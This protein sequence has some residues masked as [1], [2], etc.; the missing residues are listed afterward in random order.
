MPDIMKTKVPTIER[1]DNLPIPHI[2]WPDVHPEPNFVP[3]P[4]N[5]PPNIMKRGLVTGISNPKFLYWKK[6]KITGPTI[7]P[8]IKNDLQTKPVPFAEITLKYIS[9]IPV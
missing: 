5:N 3:Y 6:L 7:S 1:I 8:I 9:L 2:P 4:T